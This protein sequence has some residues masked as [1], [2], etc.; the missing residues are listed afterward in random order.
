MQEAK[1]GL[2]ELQGRLEKDFIAQEYPAPQAQFL[3]SV[4]TRLVEQGLLTPSVA[5]IPT[6]LAINRPLLVDS[7]K[8]TLILS[9]YSM[10]D[11]DHMANEVVENTLAET[12]FPSTKHFRSALESHFR[13]L[14]FRDKSEDIARQAIVIPPEEKSLALPTPPTIAA[15]IAPPSPERKEL[16]QEKISI[17]TPPS[18]ISP[19]PADFKSQPQA[20]KTP[21]TDIPPLST[22]IKPQP[23]SPE[24]KAILEKRSLQLLTPHMGIQLAKEITEELTKTF[25]G[26]PLPVSQAAEVK[27]PYS[28]TNVIQ[29]Q[30]KH[31]KL[32]ESQSRASRFQKLLKKLLK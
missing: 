19:I 29:Y 15:T 17:K 27:S 5:S 12:P 10:E 30:L 8:A 24:L 2:N 3:A 4:G 6:P 18:N 20:L 7:I 32:E 9:D 31:L 21:S 11:A 22:P 26:T 23:S 13:D 28:L 14:G 16:P 25:F 1:Q